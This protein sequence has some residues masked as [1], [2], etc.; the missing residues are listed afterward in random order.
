M[1]AKRP[2]TA[3]VNFTPRHGQVVTREGPIAWL[4]PRLGVAHVPSIELGKVVLAVVAFDGEDATVHPC[5]T[6][7]EIALANATVALA[8]DAVAALNDLHARVSR[9]EGRAAGEAAQEIAN[10]KAALAGPGSDRRKE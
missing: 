10:G 6:P 4:T 3:I 2:A 1:T 8:E 5:T 9:L 7:A